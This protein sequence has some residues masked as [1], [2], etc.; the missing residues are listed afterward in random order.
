MKWTPDLI[1]ALVLVVGCF[2]LL[3]LGIDGEVKSILTMAGGW[4]FGSQYQVRKT[5]VLKSW[6]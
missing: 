5:K 1:I 6:D 4:A 3:G 2:V